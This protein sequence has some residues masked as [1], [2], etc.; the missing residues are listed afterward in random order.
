MN[1]IMTTTIFL[2]TDLLFVQ[3]VQLTE[4]EVGD[5][6][7][8]STFAGSKAVGGFARVSK[9]RLIKYRICL[10]SAKIKHRF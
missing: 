3:Q 2:H 8:T 10:G 6:G 7:T 1:W 9:F 4:I 5:S